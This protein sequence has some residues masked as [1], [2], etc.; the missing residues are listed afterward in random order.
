MSSSRTLRRRGSF[1]E[2]EEN[3][4]QKTLAQKEIIS[5][6]MIGVIQTRLDSLRTVADDRAY[7]LECDL[8]AN[9]DHSSRLV[10]QLPDPYTIRNAATSR[11]KTPTTAM[12]VRTQMLM[13][14]LFGPDDKS[15]ARN[16]TIKKSKAELLKTETRRNKRANLEKQLQTNIERHVTRTVDSVL[17]SD[18][19]GQDSIELNARLLISHTI[20]RMRIVQGKKTFKK[21]AL[22]DL[23]C[24][25]FEH[26]FWHV[27]Y[28]IF[29][30]KPTPTDASYDEDIMA[31]ICGQYVKTLSFL[32][33][34]KDLIFRIYPYAI[35]SAVCS[36]F[37]YL[38]PGSRHLYTNDFKSQVFVLICELLLG[39]KLCPISVHTMRKQYFPEDVLDD[40]H[41]PVVATHAPNATG[42]QPDLLSAFGLSSAPTRETGEP[43]PFPRSKSEFTLLL[44]KIPP[45]SSGPRL[46]QLRSHFDAS[47]VSPLMKEYLANDKDGVKMPCLLRRTTPVP[48]CIVGGEDT[49][50]RVYNRK[51]VPP[52]YAHE[53]AARYSEYRADVLH[54][55]RDAR[56]A[57]KLINETKD[58]VL[59]GGK[60][61]IKAYK[62]ILQ[63]QANGFSASLGSLDAIKRIDPPGS[64]ERLA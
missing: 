29:R 26:L 9:I 57:L 58:I 49:F 42:S 52:E 50:K 46:H 27:F 51:M 10:A 23:S 12:N 44:E 43:A 21:F 35:A 36:G 33:S 22:S 17:S 4:P 39:L 60:A 62:T 47:Q 20:E 28:T 11:S 53:S 13:E 8:K 7:G 56:H 19:R 5:A 16:K 41:A 15:R 55:Q 2:D 59:N 48:K 3:E 14:R 38:F 32:R 61:A 54:Y 31:A 64:P 45:P 63:S 6:Q 1:T 25:Q 30:K 24:K 34:N 40:L 37:H 18:A